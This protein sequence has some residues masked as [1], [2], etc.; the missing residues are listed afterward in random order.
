MVHISKALRDLVRKRA[1]G[2]CEYCCADGDILITMHIEHIKPVAKDGQTDEG[3]LALACAIC[4]Q[5]KSEFETG[6]DP[7]TNEEV[8]LYN[9]RTQHWNDHFSWVDNFTR[10]IGKTST[11][12]AT[13]NRLNMNRPKV[14]RARAIWLKGGWLPPTD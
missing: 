13:V 1:N 14:V 2:Y 10:I 8:A 9:P 7:E 6:I 11:G 4:N 5:S 3:N 12:R